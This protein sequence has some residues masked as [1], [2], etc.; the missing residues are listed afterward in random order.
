MSGPDR[1]WLGGVLLTVVVVTL[2]SMAIPEGPGSFFGIV[3]V[4]VIV[5]VGV[6]YF[7]FP[8]SFLLSI[9]FAN[10]LAVYT[11]LF[12]FF[13]ESNFAGIVPV[14]I[15]FGYVLPIMAFLGG[16]LWRRDAIRGIVSSDRLRDERHFTR[17][18]IWLIPVFAIGAAT[19]VLPGLFLDRA[20]E[21]VVFL[22]AMAMIA[23]IV[24]AVSRDVAT[25]L[26]N[27]GL[28]FEEFFSRVAGLVVPAF[29]FLTFYS[30][31]IIIFAGIYRIIERFSTVSQFRIGGQLR[32]L[33]FSDSLYF[34]VIT[35]STVGYGEI[36]PATN[37]A[38]VIVAVQIVSGILLMLFGFSEIIRYTR[39]RDRRTRQ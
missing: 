38:R 9:A 26:I 2:V 12:V 1:R 5:G 4:V 19:F 23:A 39:E 27:T 28:L 18:L 10:Y 31:N 24:L 15:P 20:V 13:T 17:I 37:E 21:T 33:S 35:L 25:F 16:A 14:A 32:E 6:F 8:G 30:L 3:P 29:A 22:G 34:S 11:C 7:S 36:T